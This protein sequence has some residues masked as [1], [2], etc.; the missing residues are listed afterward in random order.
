[1]FLGVL[2]ERSE[3]AP[4]ADLAGTLVRWGAGQG[5]GV[6]VRNSRSRAA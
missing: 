3:P 1:M 6:R 5:L 4:D 2:R